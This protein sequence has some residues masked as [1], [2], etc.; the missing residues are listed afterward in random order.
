M[1]ETNVKSTLTWIDES[2][3]KQKTTPLNEDPVITKLDVRNKIDL[4]E[5]LHKLKVI[6]NKRPDK[7]TMEKMRKKYEKDKNSTA[8]ATKSEDQSEN[9]PTDE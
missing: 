2:L 6:R 1:T 4:K 7:K 3:E 5:T 8:N 9:K